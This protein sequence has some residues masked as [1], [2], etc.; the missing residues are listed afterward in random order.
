[1]IF[2][3]KL[4]E[5]VEFGLFLWLIFKWT[6]LTKS[7]TLGVIWLLST[8][9]TSCDGSLKGLSTQDGSVYWWLRKSYSNPNNATTKKSLLGP[10][11][12]K[13]RGKK[14]LETRL[15]S[16][17]LSIL[18]IFLRPQCIPKASP[19]H[20]QWVPNAPNSNLEKLF[21]TKGL[22]WKNCTLKHSS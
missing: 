13:G 7:M 17:S 6:R 19:T 14:K 3:R 5:I 15:K 22:S 12:S 9:V 2:I 18:S 11:H 8:L 10:L 21:R 4:L 1:M 16:F 20:P